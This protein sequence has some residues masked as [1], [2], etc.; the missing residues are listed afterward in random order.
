PEGVIEGT[1]RGKVQVAAILQGLIDRLQEKREGLSNS[2][3][4][5]TY[6]EQ[7]NLHPR[8]ADV[9]NE[10]FLDGYHWEAVFAGAKALVNYVKERSGQHQLD[11]AALMR[12]VF[13]RTNPVLDFN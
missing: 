12:T 13:S 3:G 2:T 1:E 7:L 8:I 5:R 9:A 6:F 4:P 11:G 10:L